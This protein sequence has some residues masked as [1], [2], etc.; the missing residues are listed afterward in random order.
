MLRYFL[1]CFPDAFNV[2][3]LDD[4]ANLYRLVQYFLTKAEVIPSLGN[5]G[6]ATV[7]VV[8]SEIDVLSQTYPAKMGRY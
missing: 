1:H 6:S 3:S 4:P 2:A 5:P 8:M 7:C